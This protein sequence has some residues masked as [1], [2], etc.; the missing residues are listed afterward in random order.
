[1]QQPPSTEGTIS[2]IMNKIGDSPHICG[3]A[4]ALTLTCMQQP[5]KTS[6]GKGEYLSVNIDDAIQRQGLRALEN[7]LI[8]R[9]LSKT[10]VK[11]MPTSELMASIDKVW[12]VKCDW[13]LV[14]LGKG[15]INIQRADLRER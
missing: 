7:S 5:R 12:K 10:K 2:T 8:G 15:Y 4:D 11:P 1:M 3:Y 14:T 6:V 9:M 13:K